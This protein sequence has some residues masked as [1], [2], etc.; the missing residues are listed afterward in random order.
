MLLLPVLK[1]KDFKLWRNETCEYS[2]NVL[3][4]CV[5]GEGVGFCQTP[6]HE[7]PPESDSSLKC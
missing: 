4:V 1:L 3:C 2:R 5:Q 7:D 6:D